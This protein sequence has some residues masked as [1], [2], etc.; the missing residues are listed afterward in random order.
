[1]PYLETIELAARRA[2]ERLQKSEDHSMYCAGSALE[3][4]AEE[5]LSIINERKRDAAQTK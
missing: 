5:I 1:M 3:T 4:L 2:A